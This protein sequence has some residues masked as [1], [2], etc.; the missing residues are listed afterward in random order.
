MGPVGFAHTHQGPLAL[1]SRFLGAIGK[2]LQQMSAVISAGLCPANTKPGTTLAL[3]V[4]SQNE[5]KEAAP[6]SGAWGKA[7]QKQGPHKS[8]RARGRRR[9]LC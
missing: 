7:P 6:P 3:P 2:P 8:D 5:V 1:G 4:F 9:A